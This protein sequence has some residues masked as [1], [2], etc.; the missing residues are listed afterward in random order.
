[1]QIAC[2]L[3]CVLGSAPLFSVPT[4]HEQEVDESRQQS[5]A[6]VATAF[7]HLV[8]HLRGLACFGLIQGTLRLFSGA[9]ALQSLA[10]IYI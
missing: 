8:R 3:S 4:G 6:V 5:E 9:C 7:Y 1:M 2:H 10:I